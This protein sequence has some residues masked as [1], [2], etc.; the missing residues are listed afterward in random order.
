MLQTRRIHADLPAEGWRVSVNTV[1][2]SMRRPGLHGRK[3]KRCKGWT[4][5]EVLS[6]H[7]FETKAQ[8]RAV[9][10]AWCHDFYDLQ[11]RHSSAGL[12]APVEYDEDRSHPA[13]GSIKQDPMLLGNP[14]RPTR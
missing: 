6:R 9:V 14:Q 7:H 12:L 1:A 5:H 10:A 4:K 13:H 11:R 3:Y 8:A 2:D